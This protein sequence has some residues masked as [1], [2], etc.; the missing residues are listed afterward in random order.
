[1]STITLQFCAS[2]GLESAVIEWFGH[3]WT[4][5]VDTV[6]DDG[7]LLGARMDGGVAIRQPG[8]ATFSRT[9]RVIL[10]TTAEIAAAYHDFLMGQIG[11]RYDVEG[12]C[13]FIVGR[14]WRDPSRWFCSELVSAGLERAG[15]FPS[16]LST[17]SNRITPP[18][19][20]LA[21]SARVSVPA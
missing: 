21:L 18:D 9:E 12:I 7:T 6:L 16:P 13:A 11:K 5:H 10:P 2:R 20:L 1:M 19:L 15:Y 4:S 3:G 14:N 8:Y 17:P